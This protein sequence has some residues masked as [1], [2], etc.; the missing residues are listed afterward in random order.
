MAGYTRQSASAIQPSLDI[1]ASS[2]NNEFNQLLSAFDGTTG[3]TH[4][5]ATGDGP[6]SLLIHL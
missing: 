4:T 2:L 1:T 5:G 6:K 3:H